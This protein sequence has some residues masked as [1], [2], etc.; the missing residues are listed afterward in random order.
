MLNNYALQSDLY[1]KGLGVKQD[2]Y[3]AVELLQKAVKH[4]HNKTGK[5]VGYF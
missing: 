1:L 2:V 3:K 5:I 4:N